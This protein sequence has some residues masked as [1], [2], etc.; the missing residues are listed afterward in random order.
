MIT[1][2]FHMFIYLISRKMKVI[3]N[4]G[5][6]RFNV[7]VT[8]AWKTFVG[9]NVLSNSVSVINMPKQLFGENVAAKTLLC[10][11]SL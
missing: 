3:I 9:T 11:G 7:P 6:Q 2:Y 4:V 1:N 5:K 8:S 10:G